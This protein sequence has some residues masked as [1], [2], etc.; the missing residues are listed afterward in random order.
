VYLESGETIVA[1]RVC[2]A[3]LAPEQSA[4]V[5]ALFE[6]LARMTTGELLQSQ[7]A[8]MGQW[9]CKIDVVETSREMMENQPKPR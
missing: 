1:R 5:P 4:E 7:C 2:T 9:T 6:R 8:P 3:V